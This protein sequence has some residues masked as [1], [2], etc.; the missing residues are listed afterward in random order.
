MQGHLLTNQERCKRGLT[1]DGSCYI[2]GHKMENIG[3][4]LRTFPTVQVVWKRA[5]C[6]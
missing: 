6:I 2:Y 4:V 3:H 1:D 5:I